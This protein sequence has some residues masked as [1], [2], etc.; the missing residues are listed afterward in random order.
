MPK[1]IYPD[2]LLPQDGNS[3]NDRHKTLNVED[4]SS[5][6]QRRERVLLEA[7][8]ELCDI[9]VRKQNG[10]ICG[11]I[12][13]KNIQS[14]DPDCPTCFGVGYVGGYDLLTIDLIKHRMERFDISKSGNE[15]IHTPNYTFVNQLTER[16]INSRKF[17]LRFPPN[18]DQYIIDKHRSYVVNENNCWTSLT[19]FLLSPR[20]IVIRSNGDRYRVKTARLS[21]PI[22]GIRYHQKIIVQFVNH[23]DSIYRIGMVPVNAHYDPKWEKYEEHPS[24]RENGSTFLFENYMELFSL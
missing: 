18:D 8:G 22:R 11:C 15:S 24:V 17:L 3:N 9:W 1:I 6:I 19:Q 4:V 21:D 7:I 10:D 5:E 23:S 2:S 13:H 16:E 14:A 12:K 20:D